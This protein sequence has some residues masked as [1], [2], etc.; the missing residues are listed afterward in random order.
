M[1]RRAFF[2]SPPMKDVSSKPEKAKHNADQRLI[3]P[4]VSSRG[5]RLAGAKL[6]AEPTVAS[7][8]APATISR[9]A[10]IQFETPPRICSHRPAPSPR[11]FRPRQNAS[12]PMTKIVEKDRLSASGIA[13]GPNTITAFAATNSRS[14]GK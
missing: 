1:V 7:D 8:T 9:K 12:P 6:V 5:R 14:E 4:S 3:V 11:R 13:E 10:G 2:T